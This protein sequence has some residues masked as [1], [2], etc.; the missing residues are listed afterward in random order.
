MFTTD[1]I[2]IIII[3]KKRKSV[4]GE[5]WFRRAIKAVATGAEH[6]D[7]L[8]YNEKMGAVFKR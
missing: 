2:H 7:T 4:G 6:P 5:E 1:F 3:I 8:C